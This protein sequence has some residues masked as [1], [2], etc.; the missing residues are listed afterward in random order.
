[1]RSSGILLRASTSARCW[2]VVALRI[3]CTATLLFGLAASAQDETPSETAS[4]HEALEAP[5]DEAV[6]APTDEAVESSADDAGEVQEGSAE[7]DRPKGRE[8][9]DFAAETEEPF[10]IEPI[11]TGDIEEILIQGEAGTGTP[12]AAPI[13]VVGFDMDTLSKEGI[14]DIRDL[15]N[16]TPSLEIKSAFAATNPAIFI[17]G[18]GL[19]DYNANAASAVAIYQDGVYMQ[20]GAIQLFGFFDQERVEVLR[21][22]QG[23]FYRNA[24][25]GAILVKSR[26]PTEEFE[27]FLSGT[28]GRFDQFDLSGAISGPIVQDWLSG[29]VSGYYN[30]RDGTTKNRCAALINAK[31]LAL[32]PC[33][34]ENDFGYLI[35]SDIE[36]RVNDIDAYGIRGLLLLAPPTLDMEW[37]LNLHGRQNLGHAYQYQH[38]GVRIQPARPTAI[39]PPVVIDTG[40]IGD[41]ASYVDDDRDPFAGAYDINGPEDLDIFGTNL[42]WTWHFGD[43]YEFESIT[44]YEWHDRY[45]YENSDASPKLSSHSK[46]TDTAWQFSEE[47]NLRGEWI[48]SDI[49]DGGWSL[50]AFY[51]Q[52][53]LEVENIYDAIGSDQ[54]QH[55]EQTLRN[56]GAYI[57][58]DY[59]IRPGCAPIGCDFKFDIGVRY[60]VEYKQF[61]I[62]ACNYAQGICDPT[63]TT[64]TGTENEMWDGWGGDF[65]LSWF[66][67]DQE[68]N[69][70][71]KY[72]RG[73]KGGHFNGGATTQFDIITGVR[74]E[75]VDSYEVGLRAH[76]F[77]GRLMTNVTGFYYDYQDLQVFKTEQSLTAFFSTN[78]LVNAKGA[79]IYGIELDLAAQPIEGMNIT[80]NAAWVESVYDEFITLLP[81]RFRKQRPGG[82]GFFPP[83]IVK[84][85]FD[86]SGND[87]IGSPRFSFTGSIDYEIPLPGGIAG[88]FLPGK[89]TPRYSFSWKDDIYFDS[90]SGTGAYLNFPKAYFGQEA[91]WIHNASL[92]WR[93]EN[94]R[95]EI[96]GWVHN[97]LDQHYK[98][99]SDDLSQGLNYVLNVWADPRTYGVSITVS[100]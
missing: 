44:A 54:L 86:Y 82:M 79:E 27:A 38:H 15:A 63:R 41:N 32:S 87:L 93:S 31:P 18:I 25:A 56:F 49:G 17:R 57:Q 84:F 73:W 71:L 10:E 100:Y 52:E 50:G 22:P 74:P 23:T 39:N 46:Y 90:S 97:F 1:M 89:L 58:S 96:T 67:D 69:V 64:I 36:E 11:Q 94:D 40:P 68:N 53:D 8:L 91:F 6:E 77:D 65:I 20:S 26:Q 14:R 24:S 55:Y 28:Y 33:N 42:T 60:N 51:L 59:T 88:P 9:E 7:T 61:D 37:L 81:F 99:S 83:I 12:K 48:G 72:S 4:T 35:S 3:C 75:I 98:T 95:F 76:W 34:D 80:F 70:Y 19:D 92:S 62:D 85:P 21:G 29:R 66:Y 5:T 16:F 78:K 30:T 13:S 2:P 47:L 43:S 45:T